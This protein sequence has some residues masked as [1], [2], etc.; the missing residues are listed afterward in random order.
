MQQGEGERAKGDKLRV[1]AFN[2]STTELLGHHFY[3]SA[4]T[5]FLSLGL[6][7]RFITFDVGHYQHN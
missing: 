5:S 6:E 2:E 4:N 1:F 3:I 7:W